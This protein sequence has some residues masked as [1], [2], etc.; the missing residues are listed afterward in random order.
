MPLP[1]PGLSCTRLATIIMTSDIL[2]RKEVAEL[3]RIAEDTVYSR[4]RGASYRRS[5]IWGQWRI[6]RAGLDA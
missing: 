3:L 2:N 4:H 5:K 1:W 6:R